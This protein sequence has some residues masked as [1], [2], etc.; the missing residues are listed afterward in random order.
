MIAQVA[1]RVHE[2]GLRLCP[3]ITRILVTCH[4][5][6]DTPAHRGRRFRKGTQA[7]LHVSKS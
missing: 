6:H 5:E 3:K 7:M 4:D 1:P 2:S